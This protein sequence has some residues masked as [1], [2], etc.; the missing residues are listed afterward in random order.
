M[1]KHDLS[2]LLGARIRIIRENQ[3]ISQQDLAALCNFEKSNMTR[4]ESGRT[5]PSI[6]TLYKIS[7]A[8]KVSL[9]F[10]ADIDLT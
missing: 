8:L 10:L 5:N 4:I 6:N 7:V 3:K 1:E 9:S 2:K